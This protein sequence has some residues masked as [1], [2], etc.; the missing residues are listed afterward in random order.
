[1]PATASPSPDLPTAVLTPEQ[2]LP[3]LADA[4]RLAILRRLLDGEARSV[5]AL[6]GNLGRQ[7]SITRKHIEQLRKAGLLVTRA[8]PA[9]RRRELYALA[10]AYRPADPARPEIEFGCCLLRLA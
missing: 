8:D 1:M 2:L 4:T 3:I 9:D 7:Q 5:A 10:P 6:A